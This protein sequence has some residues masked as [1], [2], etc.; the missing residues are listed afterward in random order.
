MHP[1]CAIEAG[2]ALGRQRQCTPKHRLRVAAVRRHACDQRWE[3][4][5]RKAGTRRTGG[6]PLAQQQPTWCTLPREAFAHVVRLVDA[7]HPENILLTWQGSLAPASSLKASGA[8]LPEQPRGAGQH[9]GD[10]RQGGDQPGG[11]A[12]HDELHGSG[13]HEQAARGG[14]EPGAGRAQSTQGGP[15][16]GASRHLPGSNRQRAEQGQAQRP[17]EL[18]S[19]ARLLSEEPA[20]GGSQQT[21]DKTAR[22]L[23]RRAGGWGAAGHAQTSNVLEAGSQASDK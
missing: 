22:Q 5:V 15:E 17:D 3:Q 16:L 19:A 6:L 14:R 20:Q 9:D 11:S 13:S 1:A 4:L 7:K 21:R 18:V 10:S 12:V 23:G 2:Q 8:A